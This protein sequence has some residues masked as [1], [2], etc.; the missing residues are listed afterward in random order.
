MTKACKKCATTQKSE[1]CNYGLADDAIL[2]I[3]DDTNLSKS[4]LLHIPLSEGI[5]DTPQ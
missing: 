3:A 5:K 4:E 1:K 2:P